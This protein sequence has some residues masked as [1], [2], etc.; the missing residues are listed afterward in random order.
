MAHCLSFKRTRPN[1]GGTV[2]LEP[3]LDRFDYSGVCRALLEA[4]HHERGPARLRVLDTEFIQ[5]G[6]RVWRTRSAGASLV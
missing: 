1:G 3:F 2:A 4:H 6:R 5:V